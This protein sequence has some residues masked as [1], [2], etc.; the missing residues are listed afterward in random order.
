MTTV[1]P[2]HRHFFIDEKNLQKFGLT[3]ELISVDHATWW[4]FLSKSI[5]GPAIA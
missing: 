4:F 3:G 2:L 1:N 5:F